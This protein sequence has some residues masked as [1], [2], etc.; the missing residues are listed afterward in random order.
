PSKTYACLESGRPCLYIG[1]EGS[2]V[3]TLLQRD[4]GHI[5]LRQG[6]ADCVFA[7]LES[8]SQA[9]RRIRGGMPDVN[10]SAHES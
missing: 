3:H 4:G 9:N 5:S 2:D 8:L 6:D 7:A 1:P 10:H